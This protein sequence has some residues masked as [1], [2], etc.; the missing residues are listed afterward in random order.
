MSVTDLVAAASG[1]NLTDAAA[2]TRFAAAYTALRDALR[3]PLD[4][5]LA[6]W[7]EELAR[8]GGDTLLPGTGGGRASRYEALRWSAARH[9]ADPLIVTALLCADPAADPTT[10]GRAL[11][12]GEA[13]QVAAAAATP[14]GPATA[15]VRTLGC[16]VVAALVGPDA[17]L[18]L[19]A[20]LDVAASLTVL[21]SADGPAGAPRVALERA[22]HPAAAGWLAATCVAAGLTGLAGAVDTTWTS[23]TGSA[24]TPVHAPA[25]KLLAALA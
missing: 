3:R 10:L 8:A 20:V 2:H 25:G 22:G 16:A 12:A 6:R 19:G 4:P 17:E 11:A 9:P 15:D 5:E 23:V 1:T 24:R 21:A 18:D 14:A 13:V 7:A